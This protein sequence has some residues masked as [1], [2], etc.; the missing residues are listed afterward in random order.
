[1][2][3]ILVI[4]DVPDMRKLIQNTLET[5]G[6][7][8]ACAGNGKEGLAKFSAQPA[9]LVITD[10]IMPGTEGMETILKLRAAAPD[11][12]ILAISGA[13]KEWMILKM[14]EYNGANKTLAK[15]FKLDELTGAVETLLRPQSP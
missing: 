7:E 11:V 5:A 13:P 8:V 10:L 1:M 12:K 2:A 4:D 14:A 6:H 15:P 9:D 3:R